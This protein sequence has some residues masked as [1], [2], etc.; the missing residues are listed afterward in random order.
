MP[1]EDIEQAQRQTTQRCVDLALHALADSGLPPPDT[2][3]QT[4]EQLAS[5]RKLDTSLAA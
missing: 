2:M 4:F 1:E 5:T 3:G